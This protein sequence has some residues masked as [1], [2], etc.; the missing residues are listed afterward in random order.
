[1]ADIDE[2]VDDMS[3]FGDD[4]DYCA[5]CGAFIGEGSLV[6]GIDGW[7][8]ECLDDAEPPADRQ[9]GGR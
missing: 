8:V 1:M 5:N 2:P 7:C 6:D 3:E 9:D 4:G